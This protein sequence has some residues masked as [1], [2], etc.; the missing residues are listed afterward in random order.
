MCVTENN[1]SIWGDDCSTILSVDKR[2][3]LKEAKVFPNPVENILM[4]ET[5]FT[6]AVDFK[7]YNLYGRI[8]LMKKL[9]SNATEIDVS[10][11]AKGVYVFDINTEKRGKIIKK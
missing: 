5:D 2:S 10:K 1:L 6:N 9:S 7:L 3:L 4:V 11:L 8:V